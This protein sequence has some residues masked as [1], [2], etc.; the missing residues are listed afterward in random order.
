[1]AQPVKTKINYQLGT[2]LHESCAYPMVMEHDGI[3]QTLLESKDLPL[4]KLYNTAI[5]YSEPLQ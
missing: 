5:A 3:K 1:M 2:R 4:I